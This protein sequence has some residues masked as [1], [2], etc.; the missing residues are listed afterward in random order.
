MARFFARRLIFSL[1]VLFGVTVLIYVSAVVRPGRS[2][3]FEPG[4]LRYARAAGN[5]ATATRPG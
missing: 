5:A 4:H 3:S 1:P 2:G